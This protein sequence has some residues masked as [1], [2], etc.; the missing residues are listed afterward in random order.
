M[1]ENDSLLIDIGKMV[2]ILLRQWRIVVVSTILCALVAGLVTFSLPKNYKA[3]ALIASTH[4]SASASFGSNIQTVTE[5]QLMASVSAASA[6]QKTRLGSFV[7]LIKNPAIAQKILTEFKGRLP[8]NIA[9]TDDLLQT[10]SGNLVNNSDLIQISVVMN[11]P[12]LTADIANAWGEEFVNEVNQIYSDS[13]TSDVYQS[14]QGQ[15][16]AS[17]K[18]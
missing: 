5:E 9:N 16:S 8:G 11:D 6:D 13:G 2:E 15:T 4:I 7:Q 18:V 10:V 14:I 1:D 3:S 12:K 17:K